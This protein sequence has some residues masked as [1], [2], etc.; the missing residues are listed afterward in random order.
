MPPVDFQIFPNPPTDDPSY[1]PPSPIRAQVRHRA[2]VLGIMPSSASNPTGHQHPQPSGLLDG[3]ERGIF[4]DAEMQHGMVRNH[5]GRRRSEPGPGRRP[6]ARS[7]FRPRSAPITIREHGFPS[8]ERM[9]YFSRRNR[10]L[11]TGLSSRSPSPSPPSPSTRTSTPPGAPTR[12]PTLTQTQMPGQSQ[13]RIEGLSENIQLLENITPQERWLETTWKKH[14]KTRNCSKADYDFLMEQIEPLTQLGEEQEKLESAMQNMSTSVKTQGLRI[15]FRMWVA[16][17][18]RTTATS[19]DE[20]SEDK[21]DEIS[22]EV[23]EWDKACLRWERQEFLKW[24]KRTCG[25][26]DA[27]AIVDRNLE[28]EEIKCLLEKQKQWAYE[29]DDLDI[30]SQVAWEMQFS[31]G[32]RSAFLRRNDDGRHGQD[33]I[34]KPGNFVVPAFNARDLLELPELWIQLAPG[35]AGPRNGDT[36]MGKEGIFVT[37]HPPFLPTCIVF[38]GLR[39]YR[40][41]KL[42]AGYIEYRTRDL[43]NENAS[44]VRLILCVHRHPHKLGPGNGNKNGER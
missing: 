34:R 27:G 14:K 6:H 42:Y 36:P 28:E 35:E 30:S 23:V 11:W 13:R 24:K 38:D 43:E 32:I 9:S 21:L 37:N 40:T 10:S 7:R 41:G 29:L 2:R 39:L 31:H 18:S 5:V 4:D 19:N 26:E 44:R 20:G 22:R 1:Q 3:R 17:V 16:W 8:G 15:W 12:R 33:L 25:V